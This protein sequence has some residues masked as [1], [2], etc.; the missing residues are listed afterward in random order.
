MA[1]VIW[2]FAGGGEA[3]VRGLIPFLEKNFPAYRFERKT[4]VRKKPGPK[5]N[6]AASYGRTGQSLIKQISEQLPIALQFEPNI[7]DLI[8]VFDDLDCR[9]SE[10]QKEKIL[11][12]IS[13]IKESSGIKKLVVFAAPEL[14]SWIIADWNNSIGQHPDFRN[15]HLRMR[16]WLSTQ[17]NIPFDSPESFSEYDSERDCCRE[18]LSEA[19]IDSSVLDEFDST[20]TRFSKGLHTPQLLLDIQPTEVQKR[21]PL[22]SE[23]YNYLS[24]FCQNS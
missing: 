4:P 20:L 21:C 9:S 17:K 11:L 12:A 7:C 3:E 19:I 14:E 24:N 22:F 1:V 5:P 16:W 2:V 15:R 23:L 18:K 10:K 8:L 6:M 13:K